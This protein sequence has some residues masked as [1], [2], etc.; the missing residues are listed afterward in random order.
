M[1]ILLQFG[2]APPS[3]RCMSWLPA[4]R[5]DFDISGGNPP[6]PLSGPRRFYISRGNPPQPRA[7]TI[8]FQWVN[9]NH[10]NS[11]FVVYKWRHRN[12]DFVVY[13]WKH[14]NSDFV[15]YKWKRPTLKCHIS[16]P[17]RSS[18]KILV[19]KYAH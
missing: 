8:E 12:S 15:V 14:R 9:L 5:L 3:R 16:K 17:R 18:L 7:D 4:D 1:E 2:W 11:D 10:G 13:K 6:N 19:P